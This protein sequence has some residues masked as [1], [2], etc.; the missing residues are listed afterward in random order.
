MSES[1]GV[2]MVKLV[3]VTECQVQEQEIPILMAYLSENLKNKVPNIVA[4]HAAINDAAD[5]VMEIFN[6]TPDTEE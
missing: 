6:V 4:M 5:E 3:I 1:N 2:P